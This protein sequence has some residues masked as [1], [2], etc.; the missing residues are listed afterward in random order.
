MEIDFD[1]GF[2]PLAS[3]VPQPLHQAILTLVAHWR[4][5]RGDDAEDAVPKAVA[6]LAAPFRRERLR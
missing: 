6:Q 4:D 1:V 5:H 2:G 3:D